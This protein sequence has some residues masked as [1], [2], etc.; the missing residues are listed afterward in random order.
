MNKKV[1]SNKKASLPMKD[2]APVWCTDVHSSDYT[3]LVLKDLQ[4]KSYL[5]RVLSTAREG[6]GSEEGVKKVSSSTKATKTTKGGKKE[7]QRREGH[8]LDGHGS[9]VEVDRRFDG[10]QVNVAATG[11]PSKSMRMSA[12]KG[13]F[14]K[15]LAQCAYPSASSFSSPLSSKKVERSSMAREKGV[16]FRFRFCGRSLKYPMTFAACLKED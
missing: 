1:V 14:Q 10:V 9:L 5:G 12:S 2:V 16:G 8:Y 6:S 15:S 3:R 4:L 13:L 7:S 11:S